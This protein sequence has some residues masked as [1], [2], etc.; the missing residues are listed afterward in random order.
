MGASYVNTT[1]IFI[2]QTPT[3]QADSMLWTLT[4]Q[5]QKFF[6]PTLQAQSMFAANIFIMLKT[7]FQK[8]QS[9]GAT[10][11]SFSALSER[12]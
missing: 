9:N 4:A 5:T 3:T 10:A 1:A 6:Q 12:I 7:T 11:L 2:F 8:K